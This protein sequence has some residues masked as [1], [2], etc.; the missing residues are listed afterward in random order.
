[1]RLFQGTALGALFALGSFAGA[2]A[3]PIPIVF[4]WNPSAA[5]PGADGTFQANNIGQLDYASVN[6]T[7]QATGAFTEHA[8]L[9]FTAF[10]NGGAVVPLPGLG[11]NYTLYV[12]FTGAGSQTP[13]SNFAIPV[14]TSVAGVFNSGTYT[15]FAAANGG[16]FGATAAGP[17]VAGLGAAVQ[18]AHGTLLPGQGTTSLTNTT[19]SGLSAGAN[20]NATFTEDFLP[21]F[22]APA[23]GTVSL[24]LTDSST[25]TGSVL[26]TANNN[27]TLIIN[28][29]GANGTLSSTPVP[30]PA[31][32]VLLGGGLFGLG[33]VRRFRKAS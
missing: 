29:G 18:L 33:L 6:I 21:F 32:L 27:L 23:P 9:N 17:T 25:N 10:T 28:G 16:T 4:S 11:T 20:V 26:T 12:D 31:T 8:L 7:N 1:M 14:N 24:V 19:G 30:E 3:A 5:V 2:S 13:G 15:F 22:V